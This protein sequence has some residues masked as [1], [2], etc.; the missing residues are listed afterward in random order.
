MF[1]YNLLEIKTYFVKDGRD[2]MTANRQPAHLALGINQEDWQ[3]ANDSLL[4]R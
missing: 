3:R 1:I 2:S 4:S